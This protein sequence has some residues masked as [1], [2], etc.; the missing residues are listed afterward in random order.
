[1]KNYLLKIFSILIL[2]NFG[3]DPRNNR[4]HVK[5]ESS[6][7]IYFTYG[8][9]SILNNTM[10]ISTRQDLNLPGTPIEKQ[11]IPDELIKPGKTVSVMIPG[12]SNGWETYVNN[13]KNKKLFVYFFNADT[14]ENYA[15]WEIIK[16]NKFIKKI[17]LNAD[18]LTKINWLIIYK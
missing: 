15:W 5:N 17:S 10:R 7:D 9:D 11:I 13:C 12:I 16:Y 8:C 6:Q 1:M 18:S 4:L 2:L 3:C 14:I